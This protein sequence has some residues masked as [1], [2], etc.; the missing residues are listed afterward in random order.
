MNRTDAPKHK[1]LKINKNQSVS[2]KVLGLVDFF[3]P[4]STQLDGRE[5]PSVVPAS[6]N[7]SELNVSAAHH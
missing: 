7:L 5:Q 1:K 4:R 3:L 2:L 6:H